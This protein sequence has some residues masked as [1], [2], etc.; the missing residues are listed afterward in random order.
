MG[1]T[2]SRDIV[3][4]KTEEGKCS[5]NY[6]TERH[7]EISESIA[8]ENVYHANKLLKS[9]RSCQ[10][11]IVNR[12]NHVL[13]LKAQ[14]LTCGQFK[15]LPTRLIQPQS[16]GVCGTATTKLVPFGSSKGTLVY[17]VE[18]D[19]YVTS[20]DLTVTWSVSHSRQPRFLYQAPSDVSV[21]IVL[22]PEHTEHHASVE[23]RVWPRIDYDSATEQFPPL[24]EH[25][26]EI[27][28]GSTYFDRRELQELYRVFMRLAAPHTY[29]T[30]ERFLQLFPEFS[31]PLMVQ[32]LFSVFDEIE[33]S[34]NSVSF[35]EITKALSVMC[36]GSLEEKARLSFQIVDLDKNGVVQKDEVL[37]VYLELATLLQKLGF[38]VDDFGNP[39]QVVNNI[40]EVE[41][42]RRATSRVVT[43]GRH[44]QKKSKRSLAVRNANSNASGTNNITDLGVAPNSRDVLTRDEF[45]ARATFDPDF[46]ECFG[47]FEYFYRTIVLPVERRIE[48]AMYPELQDWL[49]KDYGSGFLQR[50]RR[51]LRGR[52]LRYFVLQGGFL[53]YFKHPTSRHPRNCVNLT[54]ATVRPGDGVDFH[55]RTNVWS[56][57][58]YARNI[59]TKDLWIRSLRLHVR[60]LHRF[61]S[62]APV[63]QHTLA[64]W[65]VNGHEY[66]TALYDAL[67][68]ARSR[69]LITSWYFSP[70]L[71]LKRGTPLRPEWRLDELLR[72]KA[73][74]GVRVYILLWRN[75]PFVYDLR[76]EWVCHY[77][78]RLH[79]NIFTVCHPPAQSTSVWSHHQKTVVVDEDTAFVGGIDL[80]FGRYD[81]SLYRL[82]DPKEEVFPGRDY[83]NSGYHGES[84]GPAHVPLVD[85]QR[86]P[87]LPWHDVAVRLCG[88]VA[89]DVMTN[90]VQRWNHAIRSGAATSSKKMHYL[91][92]LSRSVASLESRHSFTHSLRRTA[93]H[94]K[95]RLFSPYASVPSASHTRTRV[96]DDSPEKEYHPYSAQSE[97]DREVTTATDNAERHPSA[98][99]VATAITE[100]TGSRIVSDHLQT[101][102]FEDEPSPPLHRDVYDLALEHKFKRADREENS[103]HPLRHCANDA[104][105]VG[106]ERLT[107]AVAR[108]D[109]Y[110]TNNRSDSLVSSESKTSKVEH[111]TTGIQCQVLRSVALWSAGVPQP[112][113]SIYKAALHLIRNAKHFIYIENQYFISAI[114]AHTPKN[115][116]LEALYQR[117]SKAIEAHEDLRVVVVLP[118]HTAGDLM[119]VTTRYVIK[120]VLRCVSHY[121]DSLLSR[122]RAAFPHVN[123]DNYISFYSLRNYGMLNDRP[124][125]EQV[126]VHAKLMIV[127]DRKV[128]IG[129]ANI[130]DR[131]LRGTRD[132]ELCVLLEEDENDL[133]PSQM[134][135]RP[136]KVSRFAHSL[137]M[138]LW[139]DYLGLT[140]ADECVKDPVSDVVYRDLWMARARTNTQLYLNIFRALPDNIC[141]LSDIK[142]LHL[143]EIAPDYKEKLLQIRGYLVEFPKE[144]LKDDVVETNLISKENM[145]P[146][147]LFL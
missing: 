61:R 100:R 23:F 117:I 128:L 65:L 24:S 108:G 2:I 85:R 69:I 76:A 139:R 125:T 92:P 68:Q 97:S 53:A 70:E 4:D 136:F 39:V 6:Y 60:G 115:R 126:Y 57:T 89:G 44:K 129:S 14:R 141:C 25:R 138:R 30:K 130:N 58:L 29:L 28:A 49:L 50:L 96:R 147:L 21:E 103:H 31:N 106:R 34:D 142:K 145:L 13:K 37:Q 19:E 144:F 74:E 9:S 101:V 59:E 95:T 1:P 118:C 43:S 123:L 79:K 62:F 120:W 8:D 121:E 32:S 77:M 119:S 98:M 86:V 110:T 112:E 99:T 18:S 17:T 102:A 26:L 88:A 41:E 140:A 54:A 104:E 93:A 116:L 40:F 11:F 71:Y 134:A 35:E 64:T 80:C 10:I 131:S 133:I 135:N 56:R 3:E 137:R 132:S 36:R 66:F 15:I 46:A 27:L 42:N 109:E 20:S 52:Q 47:L 45:V 107:P 22:R 127:D 73:E 38:S 78:N 7:S 94:V 82:T 146:K 91:L 12:T 63:R 87:R 111:K 105:I 67:D 51:C 75:I 81:D 48:Q 113:Q 143:H 122:L 33:V 124:V 84:N 5:T 83:Q 55:L 72:R 16:R 90:F 114:N